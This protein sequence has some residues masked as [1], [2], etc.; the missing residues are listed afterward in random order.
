MATDAHT[1]NLRPARWAAV[2]IKLATVAL[3]VGPTRDRYRREFLADLYTMTR[4][5]QARY[6]LGTTAH[7]L[8]LRHAVRLDSRHLLAGGHDMLVPAHRPLRCRLN[9]RH[10]WHGESTEDGER[11]LRCRRC[12]KDDTGPVLT[13][14]EKLIPPQVLI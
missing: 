6:S 9:I 14:T 7:C 12:G 13:S 1:Q 2:T 4:G 10:D 3:P 11:Y 5:E 8:A